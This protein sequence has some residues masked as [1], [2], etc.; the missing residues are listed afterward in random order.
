VPRIKAKTDTGARTSSLHAFRLEEFVEGDTLW[1]RFEIQPE[2]RSARNAIPVTLPVLEHRKV[3][4]SNGTVQ[5]RPVIQTTLAALGQEFTIDLTLTNR[6]EMGFRMLIGRAALRKR[7]LVD[8]T[9][10]FLGGNP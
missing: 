5:I 4:S 1:A 8:P 7:F 9:R 10:S 3:R 2:Q 6:D